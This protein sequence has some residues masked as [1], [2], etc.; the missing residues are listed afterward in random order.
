MALLLKGAAQW[1]DSN[2]RVRREAREALRGGEWPPEVVERALENILADDR[3][4]SELQRSGPEGPLLR[5]TIPDQPEPLRPVLAILPGNVL[6]PAVATAYCAAAAG[7]TV[8]LKSSSRELRLADVVSEQFDSLGPPVA[9][10]LRAM[11][12][13]GGDEDF[14]AKVFPLARRI[15]AFGSDR[16]I[17]DI[18][19]RTPSDVAI[20]QYGS[21]YSIGYVPADAGIGTA[22]QGAAWDVALFDQ[23]GCLSPQTIYAQGDEARAIVFAHALRGALAD[24]GRSLPRAHAGEGEKA[25]VAEFVRRLMVRA[26]PPKTHALDTVLI[27][28]D[29]GGVPE[30]VIGTEAFSTPT[31]TGFGRIVIIKPCGD[32]G[33]AAG[34]AQSLGHHLDSIGVAGPLTSQLEAAFAGAGASRLCPLGEMQ[35]PPLGY[36]PKIAD[37]ALEERA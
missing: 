24:V 4:L 27:G 31:C 5:K 17:G 7:A 23:R 30:Y 12:W 29:V 32:A 9:G 20:T 1:R 25:A 33:R 8:M 34:A 37:F 36:R 16:T 11:R 22:A 19:R 2:S 26:L 6:G 21:A 13:S 18:K 35:R 14:E 10:T 15:V 3:V 28:P